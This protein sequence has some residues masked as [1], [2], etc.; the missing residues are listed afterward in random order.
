[1][2]E[3]LC[4]KMFIC[5]CPEDREVGKKKINKFKCINF[6]YLQFAQLHLAL[7]A[8]FGSLFSLLQNLTGIT[9]KNASLQCKKNLNNFTLFLVVIFFSIKQNKYKMYFAIN[10]SF[11]TVLLVSISAKVCCFC[12]MCVCSFSLLMIHSF[13]F[14]C[15]QFGTLVE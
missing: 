15:F 11:F 2:T 7:P 6:F 13:Y 8:I 4:E 3:C 9:L 10:K 5:I 14:S 12:V 1:M